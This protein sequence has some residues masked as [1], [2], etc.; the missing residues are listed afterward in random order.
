[1]LFGVRDHGHDEELRN[2]LKIKFDIWD[3]SVW[4]PK[5]FRNSL[6]GVPDVSRNVWV[7]EHFIWS[8]WESPQGFWKGQKEVLRSPGARRQG[9]RVWTQTPGAPGLHKTSF[10]AFQ[11][12]CGLSPLAQIK[13]YRTQTFRETS[14]TPSGEFRNPSESKHY[15]PIYQSLSPDHFGVPLMSVILS[16]T[17]N[18]IR[19]PTYITHKYY[20]VNEC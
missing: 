10:C 14:G 9:S 8:K 20:I 17:P 19:L 5:G 2:G 7:R 4:S 15:Y 18:N 6:D 12:P 3:N 11:K 13:C 1:M 16:G